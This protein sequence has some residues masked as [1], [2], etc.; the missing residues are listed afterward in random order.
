MKQVVVLISGNGSNLQALIDNQTYLNAS[1]SLV[2]SNKK[3]ALGLERASKHG[4]KSLYF[5]ISSS[6]NRAQYNIDLADL[7]L[8]TL[9]R[10]PDLIVLAGFMFILSPDFLS[11]FTCGILNLHPALPNQYD[12]T[13]AIE[14]A[15]EDS[16]TKG[17]RVTGVMVHYVVQEVDKGKP[18]CLQQ[19]DIFEN[20]CILD[21]KERIHKVE[22]EII[23]K[24]VK[25]ALDV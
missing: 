13:N 6:S 21:L 16:K 22:H 4:I 17:L 15:F 2:V 9:G 11:K 7:L 8:N 14:R 12:G 24:G 20:D 10:Q 3:N 18:I 23:V 19:V 5:P 25:A 1:I